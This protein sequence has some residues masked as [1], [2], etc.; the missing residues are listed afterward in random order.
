ME[1]IENT[2]STNLLLGV[3]DIGLLWKQMVAELGTRQIIIEHSSRC[4]HE[5]N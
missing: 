2:M 5:T 1:N 3:T 4:F